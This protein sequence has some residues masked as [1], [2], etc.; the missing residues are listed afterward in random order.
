MERL[1][2]EEAVRVMEVV[3]DV[4]GEMVVLGVQGDEGEVLR[5]ALSTGLTAYDASYVVV[6]ERE[7]LTLVTKAEGQVQMLS[8]SELPIFPDRIID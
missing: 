3:A 1:T 4:V 5:M 2:E 8:F 6:A 7:E